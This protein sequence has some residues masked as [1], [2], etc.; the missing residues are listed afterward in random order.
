MTKTALA[1][2]LMILSAAALAST[3][4][5]QPTQRRAPDPRSRGGGDCRDNPYNCVDAANPL[6]APDTVW[7]EEMTWMDVRDAMK[8][9]KATINGVSIADKAKAIELA[10]KVVDARA[11]R[12]VDVIRKAIA[13][14]G[15]TVSP[16]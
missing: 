2:I 5:P 16:Q 11:T 6:P 3:Q 15:R 10:K 12:T 1:L 9:G 7:L 8:A 13:N 4:E 14:K